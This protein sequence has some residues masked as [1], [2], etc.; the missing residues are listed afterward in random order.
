MPWKFQFQK[1]TLKLFKVSVNFSLWL[2]I[3]WHIIPLNA[4]F[5]IS[6]IILSLETCIK[7]HSQ[8]K[9]SLF[10]VLFSKEF[11]SPFLFSFFHFLIF[12]LKMDCKKRKIEEFLKRKVFFV[13]LL[14]LK[15]P[16]CLFPQSA[17]C[18]WLVVG[19]FS[20]LMVEKKVS[21]GIGIEW[22]K[23][24][25]NSISSLISIPLI[26]SVSKSCIEM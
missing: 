1:K 10:C 16:F 21:E 19:E 6:F 17:F 2:N 24:N 13:L 8:V 12:L 25:N 18:V 4:I 5:F 20:Y 14:L 15:S 11:F 26:L 7:K 9:F 22:I 23:N 3:S